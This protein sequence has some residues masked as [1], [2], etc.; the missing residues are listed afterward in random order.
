MHYQN[1]R[2]YIENI[3]LADI[4]NQFGTPC[5]VYSK[6][7]L[8]NHWQKFHDALAKR[9]HLICYAV[10]AN[11]NLAIL[12][13]FAKLNSGFDIVSIGELERVLAAGGDPNK[14]VFSGVG[15]KVD[16]MVRALNIGI[17]CFNIESDVELRRLHEVAK[18]Q[19]KIAPISLRINPNIDARTHPH[20]AT[21]LNENK[22]GIAYTDALSIIDQLKNFP[23]LKL[24][25]IGS[26]IGS[27]ITELNPFIS[28]IDKLLELHHQLKTKGIEIEHINIGGG[29]GVHYQYE[30]TPTIEEYAAAL[31]QKFP[32]SLKIILEP[33]RAIVANAGILLTKIE[34]LKHTPHKNFAIV[35]AAMNDL[36]RPALYDAWHKIEPIHL[37]ETIEKKL[38]DI[39]GP[40]CES[41]D[42]LGKQRT[43]AIETGDLLA[44]Y[45][46]GAYGFSMSSNYNSRP[47]AAEVMIDGT[48]AHLI[49][50]R[51]TIQDLFAHEKM[52]K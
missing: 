14:I 23:H 44:V 4:A 9:P 33:G 26:H 7:L 47:R 27:Q 43:L 2:L 46:A 34:Y 45:S 51:E 16:E 50:A 22:F 39:V 52:I 32:S 35:D 30:T 20:I 31:S 25:G 49:R 1:N 40:V 11:T 15:K 42:F 38:Y 17:H 19:K 28:A 13:L 21:G 3:P 48:E 6:E 18:S 8:L 29:L 12:N 5:Y 37:K 24:I 41:A 10:K 36:L